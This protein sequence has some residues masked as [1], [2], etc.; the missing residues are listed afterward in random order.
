MNL[1]EDSYSVIDM[2]KQRLLI[3]VSKLDNI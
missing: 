3:Q 1:S 2:E